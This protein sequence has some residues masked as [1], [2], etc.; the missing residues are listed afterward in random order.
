MFGSHCVGFC[1]VRGEL[2][3][4]WDLELELELKKTKKT[5]SRSGKEDSDE[6]K[7]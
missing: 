7:S 6:L 2:E 3:W 1:E 4:K 5:G